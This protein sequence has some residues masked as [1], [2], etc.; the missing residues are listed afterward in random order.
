MRFYSTFKADL[1]LYQKP[2]YL[3]F[4]FYF[5][6]LSMDQL[7]FPLLLFKIKGTNFVAPFFGIV[8][9]CFLKTLKIPT[10]WVLL[11][12]GFLS[13]LTISMLLSPYPAPCAGFF[14][15]FVF[16]FLFYFLPPYV[17]FQY[18]PKDDLLKLY[19]MS[20]RLIGFYALCQIFFSLTGLLLPGVCQFILSMARGQAL[21]YEPSYYALY[22]VPFVTFMT[23]RYLQETKFS[24]FHYLIWPNFLFLIS[25]STG[26]FFAY[27]WLLFLLFLFRKKVNLSLKFSHLLL[28][29]SAVLGF[30][31]GILAILQPRLLS[32]AFLK[33]F[34]VGFSSHSSFNERWSGLVAYWNLFIEHP[35]FGVGLGAGPYI[36]AQKLGLDMSTLSRLAIERCQAMNVTTEVLASLGLYGVLWFCLLFCLLLW[37]FQRGY[38]KA[39]VGEKKELIALGLSLCVLLFVMQFNQSIMRAYVWV[40]V[41]IFVGYAQAITKLNQHTR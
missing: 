6:T 39:S 36:L 31:I 38:Q 24:R 10:S 29:F 5:L 37:V 20:F 34:Y 18:F 41:G 30:L 9:L 8:F 4:F 28:K 16:N 22:M 7:N 17:A 13:S 25:T 40:H 15:F 23:I 33:F 27:V 32:S 26:C 19:W 2:L 35:V 11:F 14:L 3:L 21:T 1:S 12:L